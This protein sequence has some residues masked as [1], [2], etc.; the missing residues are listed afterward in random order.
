MDTKT[1]CEFIKILEDKG[2]KDMKV[3]INI[4]VIQLLQDNFVTNLMDIMEKTKI[5]PNNLELEITETGLMSNYDIVNGKLSILREKGGVSIS[6]DD[7]GT[8]YS[9]LARL[10]K[11]LIST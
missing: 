11:I 8:G 4:S 3:A 10:K 7:F 6:L 1:G 9:S 5:N 2:F